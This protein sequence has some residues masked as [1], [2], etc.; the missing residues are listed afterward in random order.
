MTLEI[1]TDNFLVR[2]QAPSTGGTRTHL[3]D[4]VIRAAEPVIVDAGMVTS[5]TLHVDEGNCYYDK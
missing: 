5:R 2:V 1:A 4:M 3:N